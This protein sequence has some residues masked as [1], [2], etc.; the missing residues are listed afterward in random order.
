VH[1][2][3]P[4]TAAH[5]TI[6]PPVAALIDAIECQ[7]EECAIAMMDSA[8][9][10]GRVT[11]SQL[12]VAARDLPGRY[13]RAIECCDPLSQSGTESFVRVRLRRRGVR[14]QTQFRRPGVGRVDLLIGD[15]LVIECDSDE[16]H[17]G[18]EAQERDYD[19]DLALIDGDFLVLRLRYR[20]VVYEWERVERIIL[21]LIRRG[22]HL[23][24]RHR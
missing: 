21:G 6:A 2:R 17:S 14:V 10:Q 24:S 8:L 9:N 18:D 16:F 1:W 3:R 13:L 15:R 22:R 4:R 11:L 5:L 7:P 23:N 20:H 12:R 19:R